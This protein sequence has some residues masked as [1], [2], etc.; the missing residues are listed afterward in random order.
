V[1]R[2]AD[3]VTPLYQE[4]L[5]LISPTCG[6]RSIGIVRSRMHATEFVFFVL[7]L[8][9][10]LRFGDWILSPSSGGTYSVRPNVKK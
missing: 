2:R 1:I 5:T 4:K 6:G 3:Y 8:F 9:T 10:A 7:I